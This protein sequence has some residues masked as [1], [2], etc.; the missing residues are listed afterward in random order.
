MSRFKRGDLVL[1][2]NPKN[3]GSLHVYLIVSDL[4]DNNYYIRDLGHPAYSG[5]NKYD[6]TEHS[7]HG[8]DILISPSCLTKEKKKIY[9]DFKKE[10]LDTDTV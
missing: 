4:K 3:W 8:S 1:S 9:E 10:Y 2:N 7:F 6:I 5:W